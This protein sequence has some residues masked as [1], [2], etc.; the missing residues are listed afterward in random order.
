M[1][2]RTTFWVLAP[3]IFAFTAGTQVYLVLEGIISVPALVGVNKKD[4]SLQ[5]GSVLSIIVA[6]GLTVTVN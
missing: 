3:V 4:A 6:V 1:L 2:S 5:I